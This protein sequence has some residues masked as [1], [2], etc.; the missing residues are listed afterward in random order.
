MSSHRGAIMAF[1]NQIGYAFR[2]LKR[3]HKV[4]AAEVLPASHD[5]RQKVSH[6]IA[7]HPGP[8]IDTSWPSWKG[9]QVNNEAARLHSAGL[10]LR[11]LEVHNTDSTM[12]P[13]DSGSDTETWTDGWLISTEHNAQPQACQKTPTR[14]QG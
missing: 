9:K 11:K 1:H 6:M 5:L 10:S 7:E 2:L 14:P 8:R 13:D 3:R 12:P 4:L